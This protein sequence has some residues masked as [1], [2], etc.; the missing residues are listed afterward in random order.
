MFSVYLLYSIH[1][2]L[3]C[4]SFTQTRKD[5]K[6]WTI[7]PIRVMELWNSLL[8]E[9]VVASSL[10]V[11]KQHGTMPSDTWCEIW[12]CCIQGQELN[13]MNLGSPSQLKTYYDSLLRRV[14]EAQISGM[15]SVPGL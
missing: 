2:Q 1:S 8:K 5:V 12:V 14:C 10:S 7:F 3:S 6:K 13:S 9:V 4:L 11:F 15:G